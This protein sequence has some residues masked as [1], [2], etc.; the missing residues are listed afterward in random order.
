M[1]F[2]E[3][4]KQLRIDKG[5]LRR[6]HFAEI[7]KIPN[8]TLRNYEIGT[9]EPGYDFLVQ[10]ANYFNVSTDYL[11]G[12]TDLPDKSNP[13][14]ISKPEHNHITKYR[15]LNEH[16]KKVVD[17]VLNEE[18]QH[19]TSYHDEIAQEFHP[20]TDS[21]AT[22]LVRLVTY[23][24]RSVSAGSGEYLLD[25][26]A[27]SQLVL[28]DTKESRLADFAIGINGDSME[29][30]FYDGDIV[31]VK[32][33]EDIA[34]GEIGIFIINNDSFIKKAGKDRL[35]SINKEYKDI[36]VNEYDKVVCVGK[37]LGKA[38]IAVNL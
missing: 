24:H 12:N 16:G 6:N 9:R 30:T 34:V 13:Y 27:S 28:W 2:G 26:T 11:L 3:R 10:I 36:I 22:N 35:I 1:I 7:M 20:P 31:L 21:I 8:T 18:W 15:D 38:A 19:S 4:L 29:P 25:D 33:Q 37:V 5:Y 32:K 17:L 23:Y 14:K